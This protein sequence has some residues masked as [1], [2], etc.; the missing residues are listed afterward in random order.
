MGQPSPEV[1]SERFVTTGPFK[2]TG[3][4]ATSWLQMLDLL[5][6]DFRDS[7]VAERSKAPN[8]LKLTPEQVATGEIWVGVEAKEYGL[9]DRLGS[10]LDAIERAAELANLR[11]YEVVN[12]RDEYL[13]ALD[14]AQLTSALKLYE[15]LDSQPE[16]DLHAQETEW[17][18][19]YQLYIPLE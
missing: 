4:T 5:H 6:A 3:G 1:L 19:F 18:S 16:F 10:G 9:I 2:A 14:D 11:N 15:Q 7:V 17:P 13:A 12:V 8:P